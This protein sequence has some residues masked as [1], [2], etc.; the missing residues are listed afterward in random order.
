[1]YLTFNRITLLFYS[2]STT[3][4]LSPLKH[5]IAFPYIILKYI[6]AYNPNAR[7]HLFH[8]TETIMVMYVYDHLMQTALYT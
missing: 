7:L 6:N 2:T 3:K 1:M 5:N 8:E 4:L